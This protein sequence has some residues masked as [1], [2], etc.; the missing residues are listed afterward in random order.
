MIVTG[1]LSIGEASQGAEGRPV[2][3]AAASG[4]GLVLKAAL[5]GAGPSSAAGTAVRRS[6]DAAD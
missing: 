5:E 6:D 4:L 1:Q 2:A 3:L